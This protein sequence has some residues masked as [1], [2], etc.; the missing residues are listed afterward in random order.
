[1]VD[2]LLSGRG[3]L[4]AQS[5][6]LGSQ[7]SSSLPAAELLKPKAQ[8]T[9]IDGFTVPEVI[10]PPLEQ[11]PSSTTGLACSLAVSYMLVTKCKAA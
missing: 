8:E 5:R 6:S 3:S 7:V 2:G 4:G 9:L 10:L 11:L 1:M